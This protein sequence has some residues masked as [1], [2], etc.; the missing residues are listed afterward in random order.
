MLTILGSGSRAEPVSD[1]KK[2]AW[3]ANLACFNAKSEF[4]FCSNLSVIAPTANPT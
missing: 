3:N 1:L 2:G 4:E